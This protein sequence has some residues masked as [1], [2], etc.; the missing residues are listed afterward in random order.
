MNKRINLDELTG[1]QRVDL[2]TIDRQPV[3]NEDFLRILGLLEEQT[4]KGVFYSL[5]NLL[6]KLLGGAF[7]ASIIYIIGISV[8]EIYEYLS[9]NIIHNHI[10]YL[11]SLVNIFIL[12]LILLFYLQIKKRSKHSLESLIQTASQYREHAYKTLG[13]QVEFDL[14]LAEAEETLYR[15]KH[16]FQAL[17]RRTPF[18]RARRR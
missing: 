10:F 1:S 16:P 12:L 15:M 5:N 4:R 2:K 14:R 7:S 9:K 8:K 3:S 13:D 11:I 17:F 6:P 18:D